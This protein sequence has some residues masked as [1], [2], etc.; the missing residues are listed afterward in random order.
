MHFHSQ[1]DYLPAAGSDWALPFYDFVTKLLGADR[2]RNAL[3]KQVDLKPG[4]RVLDIGCGTGTFAV[5]LKQRFPNVEVAALDPD[6]KALARAA[7]GLANK[8]ESEL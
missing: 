6:P 2:A 8:R 1:H 3:L 7:K 5:L 4:E